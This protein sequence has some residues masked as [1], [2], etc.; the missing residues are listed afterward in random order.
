MNLVVNAHDAMPDGGNIRIETENT[1]LHE[2]LKRDRVTVRPGRYV[3]MRVHD[4]GIG[5]TADK[6]N[7]IFEPF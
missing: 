4:T 1:I 5:I 6:Q 3:V 2:G 7:E